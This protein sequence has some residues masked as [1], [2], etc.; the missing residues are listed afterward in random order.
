MSEHNVTID[1]DRL[2]HELLTLGEP[3]PQGGASTAS[4]DGPGEADDQDRPW[5]QAAE[6][7]TVIA[8]NVGCPQW[9]VPLADREKFGR[10]LE[11]WLART[12][13][14]GLGRIEQLSPGKQLLLVTGTI[15][16]THGIDW[17]TFTVKRPRPA[18]D[19][20]EDAPE[21]DEGGAHEDA[22]KAAPTTGGFATQGSVDGQ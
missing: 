4:G 20:P 10:A 17:E 2:E 22:P 12:F 11:L 21:G 16:I 15:A 5:A 14:G 9:E 8:F 13:P 1:P 3:D 6:L 19:E 18:R 7:A